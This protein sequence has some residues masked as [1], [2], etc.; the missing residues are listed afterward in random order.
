M[1]RRG[2][3]QPTAILPSQWDA[4]TEPGSGAAFA[5]LLLSIAESLSEVLF[6]RSLRLRQFESF[7]TFPV[8]P[9]LPAPD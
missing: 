9:E 2:L 1:A 7:R 6:F 8:V 4:S 3:A 5:E